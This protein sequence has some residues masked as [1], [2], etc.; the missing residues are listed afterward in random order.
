MPNNIFNTVVED[1]NFVGDI[2]ASGITKKGVI[3]EGGNPES[4][5]VSQMKAALENHIVPSLYSFVSK[6]KALK[7]KRD[8]IKKLNQ[9]EGRN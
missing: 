9:M 5:T 2:L 6:K 1:L 8:I 3:K 4:V 7:W